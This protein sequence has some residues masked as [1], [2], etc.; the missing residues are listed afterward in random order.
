MIPIFRIIY[1]QFDY[2][3]GGGKSRRLLRDV[4]TSF[5]NEWAKNNV[6]HLVLGEDNYKILK[7]HGAKRIELIDKKQS[8]APE[9]LSHFY[10]KTFLTLKAFDNYSDGEILVIDFDTDIKQTPDNRMLE[11]LRAK[12][13]QFNGSLQCPI[14]SYKRPICLT[15]KNGG[16]RIKGKHPLRKCFNTSFV[17]CT[18]RTWIEDHLNYYHIFKDAVKRD[19]HG[20][21]DEAILIYSIDMKY[22]IM[23]TEE[24]DNNFEP[25]VVDLSRRPIEIRQDKPKPK[26]NVYFSHT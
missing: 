20:E 9:G 8:V 11:L 21:N 10:N 15:V 19:V 4:R 17:Y 24:M 3:R 1:G 22:G 7:K 18:D 13:G 23:T 25:T 6:I 14:A 16:I 2:G 12:K 26:E 5:K